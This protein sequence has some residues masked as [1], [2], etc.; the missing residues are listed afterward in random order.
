L[1]HQ[2][3]YLQ[4][5]GVSEIA[6]NVHH[7][8]S[9]VLMRLRSLPLQ[10]PVRVSHESVLLG[11][12]GALRPLR[13]FLTEPTFVLYG[14]VVTD[15]SLAGLMEEHRG[16]DPLATLA[17]YRSAEMA[18]KGVVELAGD[19]AE[20]KAFIEKPVQAGV[21]ASDEELLINAGL[22]VVS[23]AVLDLIGPGFSDFGQH[24]WPRALTEGHSLRVSVLDDAYVRDVGTPEA[25]EAARN[26][27]HAGVLSW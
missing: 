19:S 18:G 21:G 6:V 2:L 8:A 9:R 16:H 27:L 4:E 22:Y 5:S 12:A 20:I 25:L 23:P 1:E 11:T 10:V 3:A 15:A 26:D 14:D 7:R 17:V 24:V 13:G